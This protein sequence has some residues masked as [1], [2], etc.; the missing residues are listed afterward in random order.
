MTK[1]PEHKEKRI[2]KKDAH[3]GMAQMMQRKVS[4]TVA[5][6]EKSNKGAKRN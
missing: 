1:K 4:K 2:S 5:M 6:K 3:A